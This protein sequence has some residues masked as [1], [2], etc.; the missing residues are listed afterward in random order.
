[1]Q[2]EKCKTRNAKREMRNAKYL[3][4]D[5][6]VDDQGTAEVAGD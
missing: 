3:Q 5:H 6:V 4:S 1:M 2:N